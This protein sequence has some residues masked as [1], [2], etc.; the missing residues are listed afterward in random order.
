[1]TK[2]RGGKRRN[3]EEEGERNEIR[4]EREP[5]TNRLEKKE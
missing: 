2:W 1:M 4:E 5:T 3:I